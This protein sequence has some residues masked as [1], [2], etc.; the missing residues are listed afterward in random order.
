MAT[1]TKQRRKPV[2]KKKVAAQQKTRLVSAPRGGKMLAIRSRL[3]L[4]R[5]V[6]A[7]MLPVSTRSLATIESGE[8][9]SDAVAR[10]LTEV[11]RV[12][13]AL[14]KVMAEDAIGEWL[15]TPNEAF[16]G[17]K[18]LEVIERGEVDRIWRMVY[19]LE[20]GQPG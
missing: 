20:S 7:R 5:E 14:S 17:L 10:R 15:T 12:V 1:A 8:N 9:P 3:G 2:S 18:P 13:G 6:F 11:R 19:L 16:D 4:S